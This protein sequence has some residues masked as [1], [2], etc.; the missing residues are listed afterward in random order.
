MD[1]H[2]LFLFVPAVSHGLSLIL[3][4]LYLSSV[5]LS[6]QCM[7]AGPWGVFF[8]SVFLFSV[9]LPKASICY[10]D[11]VV[12]CRT[13][14]IIMTFWSVKGFKSAFS[15]FY[16]GWYSSRL[17]LILTSNGTDVVLCKNKHL[18]TDAFVEMLYS[19]SAVIHLLQNGAITGGCW[20]YCKHISAFGMHS[21]LVPY[22]LSPIL[23][24]L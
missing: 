16:A 13:L 19:Q 24:T 14:Y 6:I 21:V 5:F 3:S 23:E 8:F 11:C 12:F 2:V 17:G 20:D 7:W 10:V 22:W 9:A 18:V 15:L 4:Y 1:F